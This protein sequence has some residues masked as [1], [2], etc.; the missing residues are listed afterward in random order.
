MDWLVPV[1]AGSSAATRG[2]ER[3]VTFN[4]SAPP[5]KIWQPQLPFAA[6]P[7]GHVCDLVLNYMPA[8]AVLWAAFVD[9]EGL[10]DGI[11]FD[12]VL[13]QPS[14]MARVS[15]RLVGQGF[16]MRAIPEGFVQQRLGASTLSTASWNGW[17]SNSKPACWPPGEGCLSLRGRLH[18][19]SRGATTSG[20]RRVWSP[21]LPNQP[22]RAAGWSCISV[23]SSPTARGHSAY[24]ATPG[25]LGESASEKMSGAG[26]HQTAEP[27]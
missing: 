23:H 3:T 17:E 24:C 9:P 1:P 14:A 10:V 21:D 16:P 22:V 25:I 15:N 27:Q 12:A 7:V 26:R 13:L 8:A 20:K 11:V 2:L 4:S 18:P 19:W 6:P 5:L